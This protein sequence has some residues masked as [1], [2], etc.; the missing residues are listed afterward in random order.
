MLTA[1]MLE[2]TLEAAA[3]QRGTL[4]ASAPEHNEVLERYLERLGYRVILERT[5]A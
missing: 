5:A 3:R 4:A 1:R 2:A